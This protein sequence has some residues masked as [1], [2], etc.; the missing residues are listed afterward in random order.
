MANKKYVDTHGGGDTL[1]MENSGQLQ[2]KKA[3]LISVLDQR[4]A[5]VLDPINPQ[6][7]ATKDYVDNHSGAGLWQNI[8]LQTGKAV[9][10]KTP[11]DID[12]DGKKIV[13]LAEP[14]DIH[15]AST[16]DYVDASVAPFNPLKS[17]FHTKVENGQ[18]EQIANIKSNSKVCD[19][20]VTTNELVLRDVPKPRQAIDFTT[21]TTGL[22][23]AEINNKLHLT[24]TSYN[25]IWNLEIHNQ[26]KEDFIH[27]W[28]NTTIQHY[29][30]NGVPI[31]QKGGSFI[32][33]PV[34]GVFRIKSESASNPT[35]RVIQAH[36]WYYQNYQIMLV[37]S[38]GSVEFV[39]NLLKEKQI[40]IKQNNLIYE[41]Q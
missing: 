18:I 38:D 14:S 11:V 34:N 23:N 33:L 10:L 8:T 19:F 40:I 9:I 1:W 39:P 31:D 2:P 21:S 12:I 20:I 6:D 7:A 27:I 22:Y 24:G 26:N 36:F 17:A 15:D 41:V 13:N 37:F 25:F 35:K 29:H 5:S 32:I 4:I 28:P 16:K 3:Q 30:A